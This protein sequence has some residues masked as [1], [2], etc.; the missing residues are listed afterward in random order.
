M[1]AGGCNSIASDDTIIV[2]QKALESCV[3]STYAPYQGDPV[4]FRWDF[5]DSLVN[6]DSCSHAHK[7]S[8]RLM[9]LYHHGYSS[10]PCLSRTVCSDLVDVMLAVRFCFLPPLDD[11][12]VL[13]VDAPA[14]S[15]RSVFQAKQ[16]MAS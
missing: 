10:W 2:C 11:L 15:F 12:V 7:N 5:G 8:D 13:E 14:F 4:P 3:A 1:R 9:M 6:Q 16:H